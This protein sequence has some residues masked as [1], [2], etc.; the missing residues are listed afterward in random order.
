LGIR[1]INIEA[2][3]STDNFGENHLVEQKQMLDYVFS[4]FLSKNKHIYL[5]E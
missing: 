3:R 2:E 1:Y 5:S 4:D